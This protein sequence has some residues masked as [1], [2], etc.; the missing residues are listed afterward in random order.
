MLAKSTESEIN[1]NEVFW[2][3]FQDSA[4]KAVNY[5]ILQ[6]LYLEYGQH[7]FL[8]DDPENQWERQV[9]SSKASVNPNGTNSLQTVKGTL[10][11]YL[12]Q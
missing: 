9:C 4:E 11:N 10:G 5:E 7:G 2:D 8:S 12:K 1:E 3:L 6:M